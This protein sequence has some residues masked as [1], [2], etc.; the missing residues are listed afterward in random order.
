MFHFGQ[1]ASY[2]PYLVVAVAS[3]LY[4]I[5]YT[6][7]K[8]T[9]HDKPSGNKSIEAETEY[10]EISHFDKS[11]NFNRDDQFTYLLTASGQEDTDHH[12]PLISINRFVFHVKKESFCSLHFPLYPNP[13][14]AG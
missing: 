6:V 2:I 12:L 11:V 8:Y 10:E 3:S 9:V 7:D 1:I 4:M 13:P 14:P 5:S